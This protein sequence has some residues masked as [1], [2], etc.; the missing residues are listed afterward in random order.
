MRPGRRGSARD[1]ASAAPRGARSDHRGCRLADEVSVPPGPTST[2]MRFGSPSS[3]STSS[4]KRTVERTWRAHVAGLVASLAA[5]QVPVTLDSNGI[6]GSRSVWRDRKPVNSGN[7]RI[8][9]TRVERVRGAD[10]ARHDA[11]FGEAFAELADALLGPGDD[12]AARLVD[13]GDVDLAVRY[14][15]TASGLSATATMTPRGC[16]VHQAGAHRDHLDGRVEVEDA[17]DGGRRRTRRCCV[18]PAP[19]VGHRS[20]RS[21]SPA[22]TRR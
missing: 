9:Q 12:A 8:H 1:D 18:R 21:V 17:G 2:R 15:A 11:L 16:G 14:S 20:S 3:T 22:R 7:H 13:R 10:P 19:R 4:E 5:I 6:C